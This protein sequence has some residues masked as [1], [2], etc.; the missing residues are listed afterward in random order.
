MKILKSLRPTKKMPFT[1]YY[2]SK[3]QRFC[4]YMR[5]SH[6]YDAKKQLE[7]AF[8]NNDTPIV[9]AVIDQYVDEKKYY[10]VIEWRYNKIFE[11]GYVKVAKNCTMFRNL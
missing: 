8:L 3:N 9:L 6:I 11:N 5:F 1:L 10:R 2:E 7:Y 4:A